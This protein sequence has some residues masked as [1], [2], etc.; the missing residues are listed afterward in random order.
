MIE[1]HHI[2]CISLDISVSIVRFGDQ[3]CACRVDI[4]TNHQKQTRCPSTKVSQLFDE[5]ADNNASDDG[6]ALTVSVAVNKQI[7]EAILM[8]G[9]DAILV[10]YQ[11][12]I[13]YNTYARILLYR[14]GLAKSTPINNSL[15]E[16]I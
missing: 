11:I 9:N 13:G 15:K 14:L 8:L 5:L 6:L 12:N 4:P 2:T 10:A 3:A 16:A 1:P 7:S